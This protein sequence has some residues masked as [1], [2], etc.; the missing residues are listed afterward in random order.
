MLC[1]HL[2][3]IACCYSFFSRSLSH[4]NKSCAAPVRREARVNGRLREHVC[5]VW[6]IMHLVVA[7]H[8]F[9]AQHSWGV[10]GGCYRNICIKLRTIV[11]RSHISHVHYLA[12]IVPGVLNRILE[13]RILI[14]HCWSMGF[15]RQK[16][17]RNVWKLLFLEGNHVEE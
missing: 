6:H 13:Y 2:R 9:A 14:K 8:N 4:T 3:G 5:R 1:V 10:G 7:V 15:V 17:Q 12:W 16:V 11:S